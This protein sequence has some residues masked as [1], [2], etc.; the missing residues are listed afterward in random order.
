VLAIV[1]GTPLVGLGFDL[2]GDGLPRLRRESRSSRSAPTVRPAPAVLGARLRT[3]TACTS[4]PGRS[5]PARL[6]SA[7][8]WLPTSRRCM[9]STVTRRTRAGSTTTRERSRRPVSSSRLKTA[10]SALRA[11]GEWLSA[12]VELRATGELVGDIS[13]LW[14]SVAHRQGRA[15]LRLPPRAPGKAATR[16]KR[17]GRC[18]PLPSRSSGCTA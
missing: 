3:V 15:R 1:I 5:R 18:S 14:A 13:L 11:E 7:P 6:C 2:P 10:G 16:R 4:P 8:S 12:A 17:R 9:R